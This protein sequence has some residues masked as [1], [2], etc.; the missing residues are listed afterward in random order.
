MQID[1]CVD[2]RVVV[3]PCMGSVFLRDCVG[4]TFSVAA[5]QLR[6]RNVLRSELRVFVDQPEAFIVEAA[7][8]VHKAAVLG[9]CLGALGQGSAVLGQGSRL[10]PRQPSWAKAAVLGQGSAVL[11]WSLGLLQFPYRVPWPAWG[12]RSGLLAAP[13]TRG[14]PPRR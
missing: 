6:L 12:G 9:W 1:D 13:R 3:G 8:R 11:G 2:C 5:K 7:P 10:G 14:E 4:C